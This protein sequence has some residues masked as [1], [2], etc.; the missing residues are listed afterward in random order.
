M[1]IGNYEDFCNN[2]GGGQVHMYSAASAKVAAGPNVYGLRAV[3]AGNFQ[4]SA[5]NDVY[6]ISVEAGNNITLTANG[7]FTY[8]DGGVIDAPIASQHRLVL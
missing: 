1:Q 6:G 5:N 7:Q 8:C 3:V 4:F 2:G